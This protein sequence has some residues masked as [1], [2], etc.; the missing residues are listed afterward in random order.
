MTRIRTRG[1]ESPAQLREHLAELDDDRSAND[2][3]MAK[4]R[5]SVES[6]IA[7]LRR[8][9]ADLRARLNDVPR[10]ANLQHVLPSRRKRNTW[11][12]I[13]AALTTSYFLQKILQRAVASATARLLSAQ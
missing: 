3:A 4:R 1:F 5:P 13:A 10:E 11:L 12:S 8:E 9:I 2:T 7:A 6:Q